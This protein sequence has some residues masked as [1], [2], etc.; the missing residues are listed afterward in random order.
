MHVSKEGFA[1]QQYVLPDIRL[2]Y[3]DNSVKVILIGA[4]IILMNNK[5]FDC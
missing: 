1:I 4:M 3:L 2:F 5:Y